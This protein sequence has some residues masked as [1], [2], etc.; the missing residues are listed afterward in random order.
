MQYDPEKHHRR[1][2]RLKDYDYSQSGAYFV[3]I[4]TQN[5][6][7]LLGDIEGAEIRLKSAGRIVQDVWSDLPMHYPYAQLDAFV[8]MPNYVHGII[9]L[10]DDM[11]VGAGFKPAP[12]TRH[13]LPEIIRAFKTFSA[14]RINEL[15]HT[16]GISI[17]QRNYHEHVIRDE[18]SLS[19]LRQYVLDNPAQW[20]FDRENPAATTPEPED[21]WRT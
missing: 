12:I 14:R 7:C 8:V 20:E 10:T 3:T 6:A 2:I 17:W 13:G 5:R 4:V 21:A 19:R 18:Q 15:R 16:P 9:M 1:S 11:T